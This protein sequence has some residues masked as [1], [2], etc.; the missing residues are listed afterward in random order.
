MVTKQILII[1]NM[2]LATT[3]NGCSTNIVNNVVGAFQQHPYLMTGGSMAAAYYT[4]GLFVLSTIALTGTLINHVIKHTEILI[5]RTLNYSYA[6]FNIQLRNLFFGRNHDI[7][8][9][10]TNDIFQRD[11]HNE[12]HI[13]HCKARF[14]D[15][16]VS[17]D[18]KTETTIING[19]YRTITTFEKNGVYQ[20]VQTIGEVEIACIPNN[21]ITVNNGLLVGMAGAGVYTASQLNDNI[22][23]INSENVNQEEFKPPDYDQ[24]DDCQEEFESPKYEYEDCVSLSDSQT[25][26]H[27]TDKECYEECQKYKEYMNGKGYKGVKCVLK[28]NTH[29]FNY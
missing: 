20:C 19:Y 15:Q 29:F 10:N 6:N 24:Y 26:K 8:T 27:L 16:Y 2:D 12:F 9:S 25:T 4:P 22:H 5:S 21:I 7:G 28:N 13:K 3:F 11:A 17:K 14:G 18:V 23:P 1:K